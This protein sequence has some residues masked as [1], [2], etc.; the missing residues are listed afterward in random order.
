MFD[1]IIIDKRNNKRSICPECK[2]ELDIIYT[3]YGVTE[4]CKCGY[5]NHVGYGSGYYKIGGEK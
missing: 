2:K 1:D 5:K 4:K 3:I